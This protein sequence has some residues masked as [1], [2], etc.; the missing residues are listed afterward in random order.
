MNGRTIVVRKP[1]TFLESLLESAGVGI[2]EGMQ[3][4]YKERERKRGVT[5]SLIEGVLSGEISP[6]LL[7]TDLGQSYQRELGIDKEPALKQATQ[8]GLEEASYPESKKELPG[9]GVV[10]MPGVTPTEI[11]Y[12]SYRRKQ[13]EA[14]EAQ[15]QTKMRREL[16]VYEEKEKAKRRVERAFRMPLSKRLEVAMGVLESGKRNNWPIEDMA[17]RDPETGINV[18]FLTHLGRLQKQKTDQIAKTKGGIAYLKEELKYHNL[19]MNS[20]K[21]LHGLKSDEG[22]TEDMSDLGRELLR[23]IGI[24]GRALSPEEVKVY[25]RRFLPIINQKIETQHKILRKQRFIAK[26]PNITLPFMKQFGLPEA[27]NPERFAGEFENI[28]AYTDLIGKSDQEALRDTVTKEARL[29]EALNVADMR[30]ITI[31]PGLADP[32]P[33][34]KV[35]ERINSLAQEIIEGWVN[36]E[37]MQPYTLKEARE[38]AKTFLKKK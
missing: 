16:F 10:T 6:E 15:A 23:G 28:K 36:P 8:I 33:E 29:R 38:L 5:Q 32:L 17:I 21:F 12:E 4:F 19:L 3:R 7:A 30:K 26:D 22:V 2:S 24:S 11:P 14:E 20:V 27:L 18:N 13:E 1:K 35:R 31:L 9:G 34:S 37:T 25:T